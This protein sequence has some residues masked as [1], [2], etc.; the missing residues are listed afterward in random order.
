MG[1]GILPSLGVGVPHPS[2]TLSPCSRQAQSTAGS[3]AGEEEV[4]ADHHW[5]GDGSSQMPGQREEAMATALCGNHNSVGRAEGQYPS[6]SDLVLGT[7]GTPPPAWPPLCLPTK[8]G[9]GKACSSR[10]YKG[11][12]SSLSPEHSM[13]TRP[14][15]HTPPPAE[16][17]TEPGLGKP[18]PRSA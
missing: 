8:Q 11:A 15:F 7:N 4:V 14:C 13:G 5:Q 3:C 6:N 1:I 10:A 2:M 9:G 16:L 12:A 18:Q 17:A